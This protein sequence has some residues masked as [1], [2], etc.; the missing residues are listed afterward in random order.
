MTTAQQRNLL[1]R[2]NRHLGAA[3]VDANLVKVAQLEAANE[4][5]FAL[6]AAGNFRQGN[7]LGLLAYEMKALREEDVLQHLVD[8]QGA[9]LVD[10]RLMEVAEECKASL[11]LGACWA[12]WSLP[13]DHEEGFNCVATAYGLSE[14]V[15]TYWEGVLTGPILWYGATLDSL[16]D[17]FE[18]I[19]AAKGGAPPP[20]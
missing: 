20:A 10:L 1:L 7:V 13:F 3:L 2:A 11:D 8:E 19:E 14:S 17:A 16:A 9:G 15:R 18:Q 12:T 5:L 6:I 4:R